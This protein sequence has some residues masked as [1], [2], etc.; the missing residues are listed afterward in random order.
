MKRAKRVLVAILICIMAMALPVSAS[1]AKVNYGKQFVS[2]GHKL[3]LK[4]N[5]KS[6]KVKWSTS[7]RKVATVNNKGLVVGKKTGI[8]K[9]T[10]KSGKNVYT[11]KVYVKANKY[12]HPTQN[13]EAWKFDSYLP[14]YV[15]LQMYYKGGK[16]C[17][18]GFWANPTDINYTKIVARIEIFD[19]KSGTKIASKKV[20]YNKLLQAGTY[21]YANITFNSSEVLKKNFDL[22]TMDAYAYTIY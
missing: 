11:W 2:V 1:A 12:M 8:V 4:V 5:E 9:I 22:R 17:T 15:G 6:K 21:R 18:K 3:Q 19:K 13:P 20:I 14:M 7:N 10:A 16:L